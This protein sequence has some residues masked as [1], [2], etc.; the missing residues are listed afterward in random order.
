MLVGLASRLSSSRS[1]AAHDRAG[2][3][4]AIVGHLPS[5]GSLPRLETFSMKAGFSRWRTAR[6]GRPAAEEG[7]S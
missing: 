7:M 3:A 6:T 4:A 1:P 2:N 5:S